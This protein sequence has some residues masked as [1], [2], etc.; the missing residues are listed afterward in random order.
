MPKAI[1]IWELPKTEQLKY[2]KAIKNYLVS[3]NEYSYENLVECM[4]DKIVALP[5]ELI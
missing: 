2:Y 3:E 4:S 1:Y 5:Y